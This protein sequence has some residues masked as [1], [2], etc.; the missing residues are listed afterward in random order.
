MI[1]VWRIDR[2]PGAKPVAHDVG[3]VAVLAGG[4]LSSLFGLV[5]ACMQSEVVP[6]LM[7]DDIGKSARMT[8]PRPHPRQARS[9]RAT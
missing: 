3:R 5:R 4:V 1:L 9:A 7:R 2:T 8:V 6:E